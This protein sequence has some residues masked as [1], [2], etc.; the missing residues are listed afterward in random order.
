MKENSHFLNS[1]EVEYILRISKR[2]LQNYR[3]DG[4]IKFFRVSKKSIL[5]RIK[6]VEDLLMKSSCSSYRK[7]TFKNYINENA[8]KI[9]DQ[10]IANNS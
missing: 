2:T 6:D 5:Y 8:E 1:K 9:W 10:I 4:R 3:D 7:D